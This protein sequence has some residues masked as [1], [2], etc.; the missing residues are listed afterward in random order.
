MCSR[1]EKFCLLHLVFLWSVAI[2][3]IVA[4]IVAVIIK[5]NKDSLEKKEDEKDAEIKEFG[6]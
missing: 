6:C 4:I 2:S 3:V 1:S 5:Y